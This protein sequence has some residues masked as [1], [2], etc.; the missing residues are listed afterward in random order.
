MDKGAEVINLLKGEK[1]KEIRWSD[2][3]MLKE[4]AKS[5]STEVATKIFWKFIT[6]HVI[7]I[8]VITVALAYGLSTKGSLIYDLLLK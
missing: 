1:V 8:G 7:Y 3:D 2:M 5:D 6:I 4:I